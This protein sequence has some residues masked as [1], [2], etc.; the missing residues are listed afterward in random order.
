MFD[1]AIRA[2]LTPPDH[3]DAVAATKRRKKKQCVIL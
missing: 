3:S 2:V 1:E